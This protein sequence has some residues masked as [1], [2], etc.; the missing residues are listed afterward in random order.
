MKQ[1]IQF[2]VCFLM[3]GF[4]YTSCKKEKVLQS[5]GNKPPVASA[6]I[7][8]TL[9]LPLDSTVLNGSGTDPDGN[10]VNYEWRKIR[11]PGQ[12][13]L[14]NSTTAI[15]KLKSLVQGAYGF[16]LKVTDNG[17]LTAKDTVIIT[18]NAPGTINQPPVAN[19]GFDQTIMLP[20]DS[21]ELSGSGTDA[22]GS[23]EGYSWRKIS[24]PAQYTLLNSTSAITK[25]KSLVQGSY[26]FEFKVTDNGGLQTN[27]TVV[28]TVNSPIINN[29]PPVAS[30]GI[31][32]ALILPVDST[33]LFG[34]GID[35]DGNIVSYSWSKI[36]GPFVLIVNPNDVVAKIKSLTKGVYNF[37]LKVTDN[38]GL[39][40]KDTMIVSVDEPVTTNK[41]PIAIAGADQAIRLPADS[42]EL[43]GSGTDPDGSIVSYEWA[44]TAYYSQRGQFAYF[45]FKTAIVKMNNLPE[46]TYSCKLTVTDDGGLSASDEVIV[47]IVSANCPCYPYPCDAFGDPCDPYDY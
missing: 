14:E 26:V 35:P 41:P 5:D 3:A 29:L 19:A 44:I 30:A 34:S 25:V 12:F 4:A 18:I 45:N 9:V 24:G 23:I 38:G 21:V 2:T 6:G 31:D 1:I 22:D 13:V 46:G 42:F 32:Q 27:D 36:S 37:E 47:T 7:D 11:G 43:R 39:I 8:Q 33:Q 28:V 16:E 15:T 40:A 17:G 20:K 10:I